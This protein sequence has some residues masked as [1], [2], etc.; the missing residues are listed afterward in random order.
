MATLHVRNVPEALYEALRARAQAR[1]RSIGNEAIAVLAEN[2]ARGVL[3]GLPSR[4]TMARVAEPRERL[5]EPS[6]RVLAAASYEAHALGHAAVDTEHV[7][8]ALLGEPSVVAQ[9]QT[10]GLDAEG[11]REAVDRHVERGRRAEAGPRPF[12]PGAK[13]ILELALR[14]S[15]AAGQGIVAPDCILIG[16][17]AD[18]EGV[19]GRVLRELG[20]DAARVRRSAL[21]S[22]PSVA[23]WGAACEY[24][25]VA[26]TGSADAWTEQLNA[27]AEDGWELFELTGE[28]GEHRAVFRRR[29]P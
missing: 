15:L 19:A 18:E 3:P 8:L 9:L 27:L 22:L 1:G 11:V 16:L 4:A 21:P 5:S 29:R 23:A 10:L 25:A 13:R 20:V 17:V 28:H 12:A 14:E 6:A 24:R 26:L 7:L 2:V